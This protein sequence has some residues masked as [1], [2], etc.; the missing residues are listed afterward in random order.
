[1]KLSDYLE[2]EDERPYLLRA[3]EDKLGDEDRIAYAAVVERRDPARAQW[4]RLELQ[5]HAQAT[6][7]PQVLARFIALGKQ[8]GMDYAN[9]LLRES[10]LNCGKAHGEPPR[11]RFAFACPKRWHT[12]LPTVDATVRLCQHCNETVYYCGDVATAAERARAGQCIA[13]PRELSDG[14]VESLVLGRPDPVGDWAE[15]LFPADP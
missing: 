10:I 12:L 13:I 15:R 1:M 6:S 2:L 7:D 4:L 8:I 3:W 11:V 5:L 14:G 9:L